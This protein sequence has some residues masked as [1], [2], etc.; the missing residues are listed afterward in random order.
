MTTKAGMKRARMA[1]E[2][3]EVKPKT[4]ETRY[5]WGIA[6]A[7]LEPQIG[8]SIDLCPPNDITAVKVLRVFIT[9]MY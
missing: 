8:R 9:S 1:P 6:F 3:L 4:P 2:D 5:T 7:G